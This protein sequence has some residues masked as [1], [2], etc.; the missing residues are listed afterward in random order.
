MTTLNPNPAS[1]DPRE[2]TGVFAYRTLL[3]FSLLYFARPEDVIPGLGILPVAKITGGIALLALIVGFSS[4]AAQKKFPLELRLLAALVAW[5][6]LG[7]PFAWYKGGAFNT[8]TSK[9]FKTLIVALLVT[10][11]A[12]TLGRLRKLMFV[13]AASVTIMTCAS[14][15]IY[16]GGRMGGILGGVFANPN[17]LAMNIGLNWPLCLMFMLKTK[18]VFYKLLWGVGMLFMLRGLMLTYSRTGF[19]ALGAAMFFSLT[20]FGIRGKRFYLIG[21]AALGLLV[22]VFFAPAN[23]G[24]RVGSIFGQPLQ[25]GDSQED[26]IELLRLSLVVTAHHPLLGL[27]AGNFEGYTETWHVTHNTYTELTSECGIP[28]LI[29]F[30]CIIVITFRNLKRVRKTSFYKENAEARLY[31]AGLWASLAAYLVGAFFAST[32]YQLF[33]YFLVAYTT[34]LLNIC[35]YPEQRKPGQK[36]ETKIPLNPWKEPQFMPARQP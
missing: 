6:A 8:V 4:P 33:P 17:D 21:I 9:C 26:R 27:G 34:A 7:V 25:T 10:F 19:L 18:N 13:Q 35:A 16:R 23:Y 2:R 24:Q 36:I 20:E 30:L 29:L 32:A 28:A 14:V 1:V 11:V 15:L 3:I 12:T 31:T 5:E 22:A